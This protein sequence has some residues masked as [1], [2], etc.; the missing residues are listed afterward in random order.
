MSFRVWR[1]FFLGE[2]DRLYE[3][4]AVSGIVGG[5]FIVG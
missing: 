3:K 2:D 5:P 4:I 1:V